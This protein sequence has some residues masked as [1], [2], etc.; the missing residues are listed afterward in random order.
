MASDST[1]AMAKAIEKWL[2]KDYD[3][4]KFGPPT[5][6]V[7]V[8]AVRSPIGGKNPTLAKEIESQHPMKGIS[9]S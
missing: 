3:V 9:G 8:E 2:Q 4:E 6:K 7:L 5:W 1:Q